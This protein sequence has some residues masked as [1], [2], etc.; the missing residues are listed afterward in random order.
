MS[1]N[2]TLEI[3]ANTDWKYYLWKCEIT[4]PTMRPSGKKQTE[5]CGHWN[6]RK[7]KKDLAVKAAQ[8]RCMNPDCT[9][10]GGRRKRLTKKNVYLRLFTSEE[11]AKDM[12]DVLNGGA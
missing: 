2:Q 8:S 5:G 10:Q 1:E 6:L 12:Q 11:H 4:H 9:V 3:E 7:T